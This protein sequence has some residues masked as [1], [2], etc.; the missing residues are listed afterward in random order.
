[1]LKYTEKDLINAI[2]EGIKYMRNKHNLQMPNNFSINE[3]T[4]DTLINIKSQ[5]IDTIRAA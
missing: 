3:L 5:K 4:N 2:L 1:M